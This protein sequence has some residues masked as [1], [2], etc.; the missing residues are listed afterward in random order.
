MFHS[1]LLHYNYF[2]FILDWVK[3]MSWNTL[4]A[5]I[6]SSRTKNVKD[7]FTSLFYHIHPLRYHHNHHLVL[8]RTPLILLHQDTDI[9]K[10][11]ALYIKFLILGLFAYDFLQNI[12]RFLQAQSI[13]WPL[14]IVTGL[15]LVIHVG[16]AYALVH[17]TSL[18]FVRAP[19]AASV[20]LWLSV[21]MLAIYLTCSKK[22][23]RTWQGFSLGSFQYIPTGLKLIV[24]LILLC[25]LF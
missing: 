19:V 16:I 7:S 3:W 1:W 22:F 8:Y 9:A 13:V 2:F 20:S 18:S 5:R 6:W 4:W 21:L 25:P 23:E 24:I 15:P 12:L 14:V 11:A 17:W 10:M